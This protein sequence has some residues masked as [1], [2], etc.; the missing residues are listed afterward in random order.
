M[1]LIPS[2]QWDL[3]KGRAKAHRVKGVALEQPNTSQTGDLQLY[4]KRT[5][6]VGAGKGDKSFAAHVTAPRSTLPPSP[7]HL[8][9]E[10]YE[11]EFYLMK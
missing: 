5:L 10:Y 8:P 9:F 3:G 6:M 2:L 4:P 1:P 7:D 11:P